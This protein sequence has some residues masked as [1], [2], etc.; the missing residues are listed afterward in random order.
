MEPYR[1]YIG[2]VAVCVFG[3]A[4]VGMLWLWAKSLAS[5]RWPSAPGRIVS[6]ELNLNPHNR[7]QGR[8]SVKYEYQVQDKTFTGAR[9]RFGDWL[10]YSAFTARAIAARY[11]QGKQVFVRYNPK[12]SGDATLEPVVTTIL[13]MWLGIALFAAGTIGLVLWRGV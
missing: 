6:V 7:L 5:R 1:V 12:Q 4:A 11:P 2:V 9:V 10:I 8:V 3:G 13:V